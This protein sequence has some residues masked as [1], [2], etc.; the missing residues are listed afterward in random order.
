[1]RLGRIPEFDDQRVTL[2]HLL[3]DPSL[4]SFA[5]TVNQPHLA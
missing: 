1:M 2:E 4:D 3:H 5:T